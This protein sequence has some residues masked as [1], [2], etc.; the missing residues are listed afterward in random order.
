MATRPTKDGPSTRREDSGASRGAGMRAGITRFHRQGSLRC[1]ESGSRERL[2]RPA[3]GR[4]APGFR[5]PGAS[6]FAK[7]GRVG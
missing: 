3:T 4:E 1:P 7:P 6:L 5:S 2:D